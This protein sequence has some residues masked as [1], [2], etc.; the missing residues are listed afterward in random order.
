MGIVVQM[1]NAN[2]TTVVLITDMEHC[3]ASVSLDTPK[4]CFQQNAL[5][6][7]TAIASE[8]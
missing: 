7:N 5:G 4:L 1:T 3:V 2:P 6:A 8:L